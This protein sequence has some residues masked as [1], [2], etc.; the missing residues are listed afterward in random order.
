MKVV[1]EYDYEVMNGEILAMMIQEDGHLK[2]TQGLEIATNSFSLSDCEKLCAAIIAKLGVRC[3]P[4]ASL[5]LKNGTQSY[6]IVFEKRELKKLFKVI[7][8]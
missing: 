6:V 3:K 4:K 8:P 2:G 1:P 7:R 5:I